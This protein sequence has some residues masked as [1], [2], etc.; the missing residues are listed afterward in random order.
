MLSMLANSVLCSAIISV[1]TE[2]HPICTGLH[3]INVVSYAISA[4]IM[5]T[6]FIRALTSN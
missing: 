1:V 6:Y 4:N 2:L 5:N 3:K